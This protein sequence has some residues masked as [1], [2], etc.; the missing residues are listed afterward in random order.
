MMG[1]DKMTVHNEAKKEDIAPLV[2]MP[3][4]PKRA[5]FIA[6]NFL[7]NYKLVN[8][9][10]GNKTYTGYY[11]NKKITVMASGMG[12][13][14]MGIYAYELYKF[15]DVKTIIRVGSCGVYDKNLNLF[16][17]V[18]TAKSYN[19]GDFAYTFSGEKSHLVEASK[20]LNDKIIKKAEEMKLSLKVGNT[21]CTE[22]FEPYMLDL[23][24]FKKRLPDLNIVNAEMESFA[25]LYIAKALTKEAACLTTVSDNPYKGLA[26]TSEERE[27]G[28][29]QMI[30]LA[31][32]T[33]IGGPNE[34][35]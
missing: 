17:L 12:M 14:S 22:V 26:M 13:S 25:L 2:I 32:E 9:V 28:F 6:E 21:L 4:D 3:G 15:Y 33:L 10:R 16:D 8:D 23:E 18:L 30:I 11:K 29:K 27:K 5:T 20:S 1:S 31:L 35:Y 24:G 7:D 34:L 19:E